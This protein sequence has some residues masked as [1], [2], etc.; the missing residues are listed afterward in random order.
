MTHTKEEDLIRT[1]KNEGKKE[2][3][4][5]LLKNGSPLQ[6]IAIITGLSTSIIEELSG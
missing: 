1:A 3:A 4:R 2:I 6:Y 5:E